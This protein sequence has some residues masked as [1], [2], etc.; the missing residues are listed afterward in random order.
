MTDEEK[1][2]HEEAVEALLQSSIASILK[3]MFDM[4]DDVLTFCIEFTDRTVDVQITI[5]EGAMQ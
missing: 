4:D 5:R 2:A 3:T 1:E